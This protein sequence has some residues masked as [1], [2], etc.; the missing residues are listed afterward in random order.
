MTPARAADIHRRMVLAWLIREGASA[1]PL[2]NM[3][4]VSANDAATANM[5]VRVGND[6]EKPAY[7]CRQ[8][9][10]WVLAQQVDG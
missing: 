8:L 5:M 3:D 1:E 6:A 4:D 7:I 2:P 9:L 10:A